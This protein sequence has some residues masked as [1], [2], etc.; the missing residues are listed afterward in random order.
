MFIRGTYNNDYVYQQYQYVS[1]AAEGTLRFQ[2][3]QMI[4]FMFM[5]FFFTHFGK[6][7]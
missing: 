6:V 3:N 2:L 1:S 4:R 5:F 7:S